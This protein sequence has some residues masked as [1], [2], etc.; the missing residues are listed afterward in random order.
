MG[1]LESDIIC[2]GKVS[3]KVMDIGFVVL[4]LKVTAK[5]CIT[6]WFVFKEK[7]AYV[8]SCAIEQK[9]LSASIFM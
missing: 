9:L 8:I 5:H 7:I 6:A 2:I 1:L 3:L 4:N